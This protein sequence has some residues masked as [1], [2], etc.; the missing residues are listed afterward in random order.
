MLVLV[1]EKFRNGDPRPIYERVRDSG[2]G[3]PEGLQY[4]DSWVSDDLTRCFQLMEISDRALLDAWI[5]D[6]SDLVEFEVVPVISSNE[7]A[8]RALM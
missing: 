7:A 4:I 6:W 5:A 8:K 3:L 2:R 1:I